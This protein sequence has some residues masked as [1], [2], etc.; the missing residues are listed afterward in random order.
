MS[1]ISL[2]RVSLSLLATP[3]EQSIGSRRDLLI[4]VVPPSVTSSGYFQNVHRMTVGQ[5]KNQFGSGELAERILAYLDT[6]KGVVPFDVISVSTTGTGFAKADIEFMGAAT[7]AGTLIVKAA[8][9]SRA[10]EVPVVVGDT[11]AGVAAAVAAALESKFRG[12]LVGAVATADKV[13]ITAKDV[14]IGPNAYAIAIE[15]SAPGIVATLTGWA[16]GAAVAYPVGLLDVIGETRYTGISWP[17]SWYANRSDVVS[18]LTAR[19]NAAVGVADG[20]AFIGKHASFANASTA[21]QANDT[22]V[23]VLVGNNVASTGTHIGPAVIY[24]SDMLAVRLMAARSR[25]QTTGAQVVDLVVA[26]AGADATGGPSLASLP[27]FNT[28]LPAIPTANPS[29]TFSGREQRLLRDDGFSLIGV[30]GGRT[31]IG[32]VV[33]TYKTDTTG[34]ASNTFKFLEYL[35]TGSVCREYFWSNLKQT[36]AQ[37]RLTLGALIPGRKMANRASITAELQ[38]IYRNLADLALVQAGRDA[39]QEFIENTVV[40]V[41]L[42]SGSVAIAGP[43]PI[44]TQLREINYNLSVTFAV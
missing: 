17:E 2:P 42:E 19:F 30:Y 37:S 32:E 28:P 1:E 40:A 22:H 36:F 44:V 27:L 18:L 6:S 25:R 20:V 3:S 41:N 26:P 7:S 31:I 10:A 13:T 11:A 35:D 39:E 38:R 12:S 8:D 9:A 4:G 33:T 14:G 43:L 5:L 23:L 34:N 16:G 24:P 29:L 21:A 15:G